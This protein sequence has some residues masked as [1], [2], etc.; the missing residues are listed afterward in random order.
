MNYQQIWSASQLLWGVSNLPNFACLW[1]HRWREVCWLIITLSRNCAAILHGKSRDT[2][3]SE[4]VFSNIHRPYAFTCTNVLFSC[5]FFDYI[6]MAYTIFNSSNV[7]WQQ[8]MRYI[9][10]C[11]NTGYQCREHNEK[12][13]ITT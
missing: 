11:D 13:E 7:N 6:I 2:Y 5:L 12:E 10:A 4:T 8:N 1:W 9:I 3:L